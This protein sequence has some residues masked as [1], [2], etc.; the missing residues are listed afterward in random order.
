M[1]HF[2]LQTGRLVNS[3][4]TEFAKH[5]N[6]GAELNHWKS[7][8]CN[9]FDD[10]E[11]ITGL[12]L[13]LGKFRRGDGFAVVFDDDAAGQEILC[14]EECFYRAGKIGL[15]LLTVGNY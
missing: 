11:A 5:R 8:S 2:V 1:C 9:D 13:A 4:S 7:A 3:A 10:F 12:E 15:Q 6:F 14:N